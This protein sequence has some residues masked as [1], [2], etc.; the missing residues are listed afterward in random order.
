[1]ST[2]SFLPATSRKP[3]WL[4]V[5]RLAAWVSACA[6]DPKARPLARDRL[7]RRACRAV[8]AD[9]GQSQGGAGRPYGRRRSLRLGPEIPAR[10]RQASA[11][12]RMGGGPL[13]QIVPGHELGDLCA[14]HDGG[15][16]RHGDLLVH[17]AARGGPP[18]RLPRRG[19]AGALPD[20]QFQGLQVQSGPAAAG[21]AA[22]GGAGL[23]QRVREMRHARPAA[24]SALPARWR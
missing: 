22:A 8:D 24:G 2:A 16:L 4:S 12:V 15:R 5:R 3:R 20:L 19:D 21:D 17:G 6:S 9:P 18:P 23:S 13:V 10:L 14:G 7:C 11:A 1:M